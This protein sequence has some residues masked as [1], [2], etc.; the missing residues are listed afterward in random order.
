MLVNGE[1]RHRSS[2]IAWFAGVTD[3]AQGPDISTIPAVALRRVE[4]LRDG[5]SVLGDVGGRRRVAG[6]ERR[7]PS[8][9]CCKPPAYSASGSG[10][11]W[12]RTIS[13]VIPLP[14]SWCQFV[15]E[16]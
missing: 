6:G 14:P 7:G 5:A 12:K 16:S 4:V 8:A 1:R 3:G 13:L 9:A 2:V 11:I 10:R 15:T